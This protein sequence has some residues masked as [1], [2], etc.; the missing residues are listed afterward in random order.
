MPVATDD[1][2]L[3]DCGDSHASPPTPTSVIQEFVREMNAEERASLQSAMRPQPAGTWQ[4]DRSRETWGLAAVWIITLVVIVGTGGTNIGG[5]V[6]AAAA[7]AAFIGYRLAADAASRARRREFREAHTA[8]M[9]SELS[10]ALEDGRVMVKRVRAVAVVEIE[11]LEDEGT[12]YVFDLGDGR[13]LFLKGDDYVPAEEGAPW[14]NTDFE[15]VR[16]ADG[17][18]I[19]DLHCHGTA[20]RP[21]RV[22]P[23]DDVDPEKGWDEREEVLEMSVDEAVRTVLRDR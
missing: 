17:G 16:T 20:L 15:I 22:I 14:P 4:S 11:P 23:R 7:G 19:L 18:L 5:F 2:R 13:V 6:V 21:L 3:R 8:R 9:S 10:R 12:G 1:L